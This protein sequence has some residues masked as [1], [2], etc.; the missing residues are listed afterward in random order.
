MGTEIACI[1]VTT[2]GQVAHGWGKAAV[3]AIARIEEGVITDWRTENVGWGV[4]H[5]DPAGNHHARIVRFLRDNEVTLVVAAHM[6][7]PMQ[8]TLTKLGVRVVMGASGDARAALIEA[9][10]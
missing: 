10:A 9:A 1:P 6:G 3:V 7:E 4:L 5:D 8:N 2:D